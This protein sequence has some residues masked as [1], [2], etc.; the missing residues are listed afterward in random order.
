MNRWYETENFNI[1]LRIAAIHFGQIGSS[2]YDLNFDN[3]INLHDF[4]IITEHF[5]K[6]E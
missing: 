3:I 2:L 4:Q 6:V 1:D 5:G